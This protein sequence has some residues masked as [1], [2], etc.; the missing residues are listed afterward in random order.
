MNKTR[1]FLMVAL[2]ASLPFFAIRS[3]PGGMSATLLVMTILAAMNYLRLRSVGRF[4]IAHLLYVLVAVV[5]VL[6][7]TEGGEAQASA[8][9]KTSTYIIV[10]IPLIR[11][12]SDYNVTSLASV[13][14]YGSKIGV[15]AYAALAVAAV[16]ASGLGLSIFT[17]LTYYGLGFQ[18]QQA[19]NSFAGGSEEFGSL[20]VM[21]NAVGEIFA[22]L[23]VLPLVF[24]Q[25]R[26]LSRTDAVFMIVCFAFVVLSFSRRA[27]VDVALIVVCVGLVGQASRRAW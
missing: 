7:S 20:Q 2:F 6:F 18:I 19:I 3:L 27:I 8:L 17:N 23:L 12:F 9:I 10:F 13:A 1:H 4:E 15:C 21:R 11:A 16:A 24:T 22:F 5:S 26:P 14:I 25:V